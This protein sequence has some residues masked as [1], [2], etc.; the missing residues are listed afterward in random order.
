M[1]NTSPRD[2]NRTATLRAALNTDGKTVVNVT[3]VD[4]ILHE[5]NVSY[6]TSGTDYGVSTAQRDYDRVP[7]LMA[8]SSADGVTPIEVYA[9]S[10]GNLLVETN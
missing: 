5:L 9:D 6:G 4:S 3:A 10:S 1:A 8:V 7:V 2:E